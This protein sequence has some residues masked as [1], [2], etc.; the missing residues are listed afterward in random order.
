MRCSTAQPRRST[1]GGRSRSICQPPGPMRSA[2]QS[3][4]ATAATMSSN[5]RAM[6]GE[7]IRGER[8]QKR[9]RLGTR[10]RPSTPKR[11]IPG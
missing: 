3:I 2:S 8:A 9:V 1:I 11:F 7:D 6:G 10:R 4:R 5:G